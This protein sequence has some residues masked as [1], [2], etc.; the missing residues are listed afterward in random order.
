MRLWIRQEFSILLVISSLQGIVACN[1]ELYTK[2][3]Y[4]QPSEL[5]I[6]NVGRKANQYRFI[7]WE[8]LS[9]IPTA[10]GT[11]Y[12]GAIVGLPYASCME[13]DKIVGY[14]ISFLTFMTAANNPYSMLYTENLRDNASVYGF[15]YHT[16]RSTIGGWSGIVCNIMET[17]ATGLKIPYD[18]GMWAYLESIGKLERINYLAAETISIGDFLWEPGHGRMIQDYILGDDGEVNDIEV[19]TGG[20]RKSE[21]YKSRELFDKDL[22]QREGV[23]YRNVELYKN[24][25]TLKSQRPLTTR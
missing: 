22:Q 7:K 18:T 5:A 9:P 25:S 2:K 8:A 23:I 16:G 10:W 11:Y 20:T 13:N 6:K 3:Q 21:V 12:E 24:E 4:E 19:V 15:S 1:T 14:D 17:F